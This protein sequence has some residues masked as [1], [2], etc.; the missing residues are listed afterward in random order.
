MK[1]EWRTKEYI[2]CIRHS[3]WCLA[4]GKYSVKSP[5]NN[6]W[7]R[8]SLT[9]LVAQMVKHLSTMWE[10]WVRSLGW[11]VPWRRKWQPTA[12]LLPRKS[13]GRR[14]LVSMGSQRVGHDWATSLWL[15]LWLL[16]DFSGSPVVKTLPS[17]ARGMGLIPGQELR[18]HMLHG[19]KETKQNRS[20]IV[21]NS[22]NI[23]RMVHT[24]KK[25]QQTLL[26]FIITNG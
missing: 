21:T 16:K 20:N 15:W 10:T 2:L 6:H 26:R 25:Q 7:L 12:E 19:Q 3:A 14:N 5:I 18:S 1:W 24:K 8:T 22:I 9:S 13:H 4:H 17:S 23:L 11:E